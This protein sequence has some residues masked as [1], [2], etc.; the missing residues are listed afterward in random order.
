MYGT[1][2]VDG[3]LDPWLGVMV[4]QAADGAPVGNPLTSTHPRILLTISTL[5][6]C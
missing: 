4:E 1:G 3:V 6:T 2:S 5:I